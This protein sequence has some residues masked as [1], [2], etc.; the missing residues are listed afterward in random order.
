MIRKTLLALAA[1]VL[2][3]AAQASPY[4]F[5]GS[6]DTDPSSPVITGLFNFD[7]SLVAAGGSDGA[8]DLSSLSISFMGQAYSLSDATDPYVQ[9]EAGS[10][11]GPN[12]LFG[13]GG[14]NTLALQSFFGSSNFTY[15]AGGVDTLGTLT[16]SAVPEPSSWALAVVGLAVIGGMARRRQRLLPA[17]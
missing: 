15:S 1:L 10:M 14:G 13:L 7:D 8:F 16:I 11:T 6:F 3:G 17:T 2:A 9:F 4:T 5:T 12:A